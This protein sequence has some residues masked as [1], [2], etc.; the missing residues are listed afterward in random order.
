M[1]SV[2]QFI[3]SPRLL[4]VLRIIR[5]F[6]SLR[7][8]DALAGLSAVVYTILVSIPQMFQIVL[9]LL[10]IIVMYAVMGNFMFK[11]VLPDYFDDLGSS[12]FSLFIC[13]NQDGWLEIIKKIRSSSIDTELKWTKY[14]VYF[15]LG[16]V[17]VV[18]AFMISNLIIA[19]L[20][21]NIEEIMGSA[22]A[23]RCE[24]EILKLSEEVEDQ[25]KDVHNENEMKIVQVEDFR[26]DVKYTEQEA[27]EKNAFFNNLSSDNLANFMFLLDCLENSFSE[28][29][30]IKEDVVKLYNV[31]N[32]V[33]TI[34]KKQKQSEYF[35]PDLNQLLKNMYTMDSLQLA[36]FL[37]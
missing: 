26:R 34:S 19:V 4:R 22:Q 18:G 21:T 29:K 14:F 32:S 13:I 24:V 35:A 30:E 17:I 2:G 9:I 8:I 10:I 23:G 6:R 33:H 16:S 3:N 1:I 37:T 7:S 12:L 27:N 5:A 25:L 20:I 31:M 28:Y 11:D 15:Y 36:N